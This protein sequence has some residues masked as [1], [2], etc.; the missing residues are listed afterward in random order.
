MA[1]SFKT[2]RT[3]GPRRASSRFLR[4]SRAWCSNVSARLFRLFR[5]RRR[6]CTASTPTVP[7]NAALSIPPFNLTGLPPEIRV[8]I[9]YDVFEDHLNTFYEDY[10]AGSITEP[11]ILRVSRLTR[12]E[13]RGEYAQFL[14]CQQ[15]YIE[16]LNSLA[17]PDLLHSVYHPF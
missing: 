7:D 5:R 13:G 6:Q 17:S 4:S 14:E 16:E 10:L 2:P 11:A 8:Q 12:Q 1:S 9:Y 15:S 3:T